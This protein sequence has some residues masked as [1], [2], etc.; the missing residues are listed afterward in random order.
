MLVAVA[1][2]LAACG[3]DSSSSATTATS[4]TSAGS[5][6]AAATSAAATTKAA[7]TS[8]AAT[9]AAATSAAATTKATT[10]GAATSVD[11][12]LKEWSIEA[13]TKIK[14]GTI[15][16]VV[17]NAGTANHELDIVKGDSYAALPKSDSGAILEDKLPAGALQPVVGR[18]AA[19]A[20]AKG[21]VTVTP[22]KYVL[23]CNIAFG[24][25]SHAGKGQRL[26]IEVTA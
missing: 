6:A 9:T 11:V 4:V 20:T 18:F 25:N 2:A 13:P 24:A 8:A 22:G 19:N 5:T 7:A 23:V 1:G 21:T 10:A 17:K 15:E 16:F 14:A 26:D 12:V 3:D